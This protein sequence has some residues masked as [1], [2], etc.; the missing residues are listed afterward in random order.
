LSVM[1]AS[2]VFEDAGAGAPHHED[3]LNDK[4]ITDAHD[5]AA[6]VAAVAKA[7]RDLVIIARTDAAAREGLDGVVARAKLYMAATPI[8]H[9]AIPA[10]RRET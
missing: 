9:L 1:H 8:F 5:M 10:A 4:K 7:R 2:R 3:Q 6:K